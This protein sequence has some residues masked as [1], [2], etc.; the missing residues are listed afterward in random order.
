[1]SANPVFERDLLYPTESVN[2][3][4]SIHVIVLNPNKNGKMPVIIEN[5]TTHSPVK[6][7][8]SIIRIMQSDIFD[9]ILVN[10]KNNVE[11]YIT[12]NDELSSI[13][14]GKKYLL[15]TFA[16][17]RNEYKGVNEIEP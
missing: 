8:D 4:G 1:M 11:L 2:E 5:K 13:T 15:V 7:L 12:S 17:D 3:P 10:I 9:R 6:Y 16:G 14:G